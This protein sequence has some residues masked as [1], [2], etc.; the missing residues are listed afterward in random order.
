MKKAKAGMVAGGGPRCPYPGLQRSP[1][2]KW[3]LKRMMFVYIIEVDE[4]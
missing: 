1:A 4:S 2:S 3:I